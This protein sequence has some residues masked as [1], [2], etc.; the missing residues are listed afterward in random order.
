M[1][2]TKDSAKFI[3][4][5]VFVWS[6]LAGASWI[7]AAVPAIGGGCTMGTCQNAVVGCNLGATPCNAAV[8]VTCG[9]APDPNTGICDC[10]PVKPPPHG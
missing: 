1:R 4:A 5:A 7:A 8:G 10:N 2:T 6:V 9:C 3:V